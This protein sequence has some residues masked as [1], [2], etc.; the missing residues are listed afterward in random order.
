MARAA[1]REARAIARVREAMPPGARVAMDAA[2]ERGATARLRDAD[3]IALNLQGVGEFVAQAL[4]DWL[5]ASWWVGAIGQYGSAL[6]WDSRRHCVS[7]PAP[8]SGGDAAP[9]DEC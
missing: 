9:D 5:S 7:A 6:I 3:T 1:E 8:G 2:I 4:H